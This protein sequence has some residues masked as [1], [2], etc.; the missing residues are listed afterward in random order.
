[1]RLLAPRELMEVRGWLEV[2]EGEWRVEGVSFGD[3]ESQVKG[4]G[5]RKRQLFL[6]LLLDPKQ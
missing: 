2:E 3:S 4:G 1:M 5:Y 6:S